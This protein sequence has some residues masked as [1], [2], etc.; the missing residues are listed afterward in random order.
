M[1][2]KDKFEWDINDPNNNPDVFFFNL[3]FHENL[4]ILKKYRNFLIIYVKIWD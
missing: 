4:K 2:V 1:Q 3:F